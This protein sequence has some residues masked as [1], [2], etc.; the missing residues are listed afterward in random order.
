M[1]LVQ[2]DTLVFERGSQALC[3]LKRQRGLQDSKMAALRSIER[4]SENKDTGSENVEYWFIK[5]RVGFHICQYCSWG[6][7]DTQEQ[8]APMLKISCK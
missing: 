7:G 2:E 3:F 8:H 5:C 4:H 1:Q 6:M